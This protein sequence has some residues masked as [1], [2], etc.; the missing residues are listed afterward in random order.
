MFPAAHYL[1]AHNTM[2]KTLY[3]RLP[4]T[5][6]IPVPIPDPRPRGI[7]SLGALSL[8]FSVRLDSLMAERIDKQAKQLGISRGEYVRWCAERMVIAIDTYLDENPEAESEQENKRDARSKQLELV[9]PDDNDDEL[10]NDPR[11]KLG[12]P[13]NNIK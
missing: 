3:D 10:D 13:N 6:E 12:N 2:S 1:G 8:S 11:R 4:N 9:F 5:F 7:Q